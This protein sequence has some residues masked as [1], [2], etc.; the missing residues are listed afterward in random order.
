M[1]RV[2]FVKC[3]VEGGEI[4]VLRGAKQLRRVSKPPI[5]MIE[6]DDQMIME[7]GSSLEDLNSE[8]RAENAV[9]LF[10]LSARGAVYEIEHVSQRQGTPNVFVVPEARLEQFRL[11]ALPGTDIAC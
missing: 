9:R 3:D 7:A 2:D 6:V 10:F 5:W 4:A 1:N 11:A 8:M